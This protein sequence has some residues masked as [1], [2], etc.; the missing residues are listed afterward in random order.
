MAKFHG[1]IGYASSSETSPGV[2]ENLYTE[3][4]YSGDVIELSKRWVQSDKVNDDITL[5]NKL[6]IIADPFA[7][8]N[9]HTIKYV[10][11]MGAT[12]KVTNISISRPRLTLTLGGIFNV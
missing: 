8:D 3:R 2:W 4:T 6:S 11:W 10:K 9:L 12:W 5:T 1:A 7:Y